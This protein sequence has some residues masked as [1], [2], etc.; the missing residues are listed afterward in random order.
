M[1]LSAQWK[2]FLIWK[3]HA[4][5]GVLFSGMYTGKQNSSGFIRKK[6]LLKSLARLL[7]LA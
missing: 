3:S 1:H 6:K 5:A 4:P 7:V 2:L